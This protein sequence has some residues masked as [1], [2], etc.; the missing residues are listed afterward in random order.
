ML[1]FRSTVPSASRK[2]K[3][4]PVQD[5]KAQEGMLVSTF[6]YPVSWFVLIIVSCFYSHEDGSKASTC[7]FRILESL[8]LKKMS[9]IK[10]KGGGKGI[11]LIQN[12]WRGRNHSYLIIDAFH[13]ISV[14]LREERLSHPLP[15]IFSLGRCNNDAFHSEPFQ[16][17][18]QWWGDPILGLL[19]LAPRE[20]LSLLLCAGRG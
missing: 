13:T 1:A 15:W 20:S 10:E 3:W 18:G 16:Y 6:F 9:P 4:W 19:V 2:L 17:R 8:W 11:H 7:S 5:T 12:D 14:I